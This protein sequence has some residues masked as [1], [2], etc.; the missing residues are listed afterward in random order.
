MGGCHFIFSVDVWSVGCIMAEMVRGS[1]L[2]PGT[3]RI[4]ELNRPSEPQQLCLFL[5]S[6]I[7]VHIFVQQKTLLLCPVYPK[8][9]CNHLL[10]TTFGNRKTNRYISFKIFNFF[11]CLIVTLL[12]ITLLTAKTMSH[13][14]TKL[15][16]KKTVL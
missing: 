6:A 4:L 1:V 3:D 9:S 7:L 13:K 5:L 12:L 10:R 15:T 2:F 8:G 14:L 16:G 11:C